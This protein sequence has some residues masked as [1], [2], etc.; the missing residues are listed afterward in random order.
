M[1]TS[2]HQSIQN[3]GDL[4]PSRRLFLEQTALGFGTVALAHLLQSD[5]LLAEPSHVPDTLPRGDNLLPKQPHFAPQAKSVI[6]LVQNGGPSHLD[7]FDFKPELQRRHGQKHT[8][9]VVNFHR[10]V[11]NMLMG[12]PAKFQR[13]GECGMEISDYLPNLR[14][15]ADDICMVRSMFTDQIEHGRALR[16]LNTGKVFTGRPSLGAWICYALGSENQNVPAYIALRDPR[17]Y[18]SGGTQFWGNG[19]LPTV[20]RG[21]EFSSQG[22]PVLDLYPAVKLPQGVERNNLELLAKLNEER[23]QLYPRDTRLEAR[24]QNYELAARMQRDAESVLDLSS[25]TEATRS[26]YGVDD[27]DI[28]TSNYGTRCLMARRLVEAGVRFVTVTSPVL[29]S[30]GG[31]AVHPWDNHGHINKN[32]PIIARHVDQGSAALIKDLK[33]RGL[34]DE[35]IVI[36]AGEFGR[37]PISEGSSGRDHNPFAFTNLIA[38]GGFKAGHVH[39]TTDEIG[40]RGVEDRVS[41]PDFLATVLHQLGL[42]HDRLSYRHASRDETLTD[43]AVTG[44]RFVHELIEKPV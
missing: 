15:V 11:R 23:R 38:G 5:G 24:I 31:I 33:Q 36:W 6:F 43:S 17:R 4:V 7:L 16:S 39:G 40:Y 27:K 35:T 8:E 3:L 14:S 42:D 18:S 10:D 12:S 13:G 41:C 26:L 1:T 29:P 25:E 37:M 19:W 21:T 28:S 32:I 2:S 9:D 30:F 22:A 34:L 44:A 20:Y